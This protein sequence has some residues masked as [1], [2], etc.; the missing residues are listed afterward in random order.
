MSR[1]KIDLKP[2]FDD[3]GIGVSEGRLGRMGMFGFLMVGSSDVLCQG[4]GGGGAPPPNWI[5]M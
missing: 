2:G 3:Y 1:W 4:G 5:A